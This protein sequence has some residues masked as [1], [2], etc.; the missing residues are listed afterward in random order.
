M[1]LLLGVL[2]TFGT[3]SA[4]LSV[5]PDDPLGLSIRER[6]VQVIHSK[7][8]EVPGTSMAL[9]LMDPWLA[10]QRGRSYFHREWNRRDAVF[11]QLNERPAAAATNSCGMCHNLPFRTVGGG[12]NAPEPLGFGLNTPHLF[13]AGLME[14]LGFQIRQEL[15]ATHDLNRNGFLDH[16]AETRGRRAVVEA[17]PG[18]LVDYGALDDE[19]E[20]GL[21]D[22][23]AVLMVTLVDAS[24]QPARP[25]PDGEIPG[26]GEPG[27]AGYDIEFG[28]FASS[29]GDHQSSSLRAFAIGVARTI[30]GLD[31]VDPTTGGD[32]ASSLE[33]PT[34]GQWA[35]F[36]NA[37]ALQPLVR[38]RD[39]ALSASAATLTEGELDL[40]EWYLLNHP[41]PAVGRQDA[42]TRQGHELLV[43]MGC[44]TCHVQDWGLKAAEPARGLTGDR[45]FFDLGVTWSPARKRLEGRLNP[46][47][48]EAPGP[49]GQRLLQP[50]RGAFT[51]SGIY[52]DFRHHDLGKRFYE[53]GWEEGR[54]TV[55]RRFRTP[56]LWGVGSTAPYGHDGRSP[57]L[58]DV[59]RRHGGEAAESAAAYAAAPARER[60]ALIAFLRSLV[61]YS[62]DVL[63]T[64]L[65]GN[66]KIEE[67]FLVGELEVGQERFHPELLFR[68]PPRYQGWTTSQDGDTY[69]SYA[70][71]NTREAYGEDLA[72]LKDA[73][74]DG[75]PDRPPAAPLPSASLPP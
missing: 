65:D 38:A 60:K 47:Y 33:G 7:G 18:V 58:D 52:T 23:N 13:G 4:Q 74:A 15:L 19:D 22:L 43:R 44:T 12:G 8:P 50:L 1:A 41:R 40:F 5:R 29:I 69:F 6:R 57:T 39:P 66:G 11:S 59:I 53:Y 35:G 51:V 10:Y 72:A 27:V 14:A 55:L 49:E 32:A 67:R 46:L 73:N 71:L 42:L 70:L 54:L 24:G 45:R 56:P 26:L 28:V 9:Q 20:D 36:S 30:M 34:H 68:T 16:P 21:P 37:G 61:L 2:G 31:I 64:D 25:R 75:L 62:P 63:P 48:T 17:A 3:A